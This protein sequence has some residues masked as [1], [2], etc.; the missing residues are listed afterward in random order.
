M[1]NKLFIFSLL[2]I[3]LILSTSVAFARVSNRTGDEVVTSTDTEDNV[4]THLQLANLS[5]ATSSIL[6]DLSDNS[7][8][9]HLSSTGSV[10]VSQIRLDW[11]TQGAATTTLKV[12]VIASTTPAGNLADIYWFDE[13]SFISAT[14]DTRRQTKILDYSPSVVKTRV[15]SGVPTKIVTND[16]SLSS[17]TYATTTKY[18]SPRGSFTTNPGVGD[19][20][21]YVYEQSGNATTSATTLYRTTE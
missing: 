8:F 4:T 1:K 21:M 16:S 6:V 2:L 19:L 15:A 10:D 5:A 3:G 7:N 20:V 13:V 9:K 11:A 18:T 14:V 17:S 12:G